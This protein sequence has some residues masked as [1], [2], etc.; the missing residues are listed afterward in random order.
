MNFLH[1]HL[2]N[3][4]TAVQLDAG[5][6]VAL[7]GHRTGDRVT[8]GIRPEHLTLDGADL[9]LA[10]DLVEP[11]GSET[12]IH[13]RIIGHDNETIVIKAPGAVM[14]AETVAV[15]MQASHAHVFDATT[16]QRLEPD[17]DH[18]I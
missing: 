14:P 18:T 5:P 13:G 16:G 2:I 12:L 1:G 7:Q 4:G 17:G 11:L 9:T 8:L 3:A 10:V 6:L 15:S